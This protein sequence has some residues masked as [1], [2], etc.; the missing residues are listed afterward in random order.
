MFH[1]LCYSEKQRPDQRPQSKTQDSGAGS[2]G[3]QH[4]GLIPYLPISDSSVI[5][6]LVYR[7][8]IVMIMF[9]IWDAFDCFT[10]INTFFF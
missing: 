1:L 2:G 7:E 6:D 3:R 9:N 10:N 5:V 4:W 8:L